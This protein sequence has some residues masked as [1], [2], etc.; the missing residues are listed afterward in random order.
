MKDNKLYAVVSR[1]GFY[2]EDDRLAIESIHESVEDAQEAALGH[3]PD[4]DD[5]RQAHMLAH[6]Q[7][8]YATL[9][10]WEVLP[11]SGEPD[12]EDHTY[13]RHDHDNTWDWYKLVNC[14]D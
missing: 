13:L 2:G 1:R 9:E 5:D 11:I 10:A 6:N 12:D 4:W 3:G 14:L 8:G 7:S